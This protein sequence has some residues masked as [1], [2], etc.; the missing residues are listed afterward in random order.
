MWV[1]G[2]LVCISKVYLQKSPSLSLGISS[3]W[4][5]QSLPDLGPKC[6]SNKSA[7][8]K[9]TQ[10]VHRAWLKGGQRIRDEARVQARLHHPKPFTGLNPGRRLSVASTTARE[11]ERRNQ[12]RR[13]PYSRERVLVQEGKRDTQPLGWDDSPVEKLPPASPT[14]LPVPGGRLGSQGAL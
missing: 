7:E 6:W 14:V 13:V 1:L 12:V 3:S 11:Q 8:D 2:P 9:K 5:G 4:E 10:S